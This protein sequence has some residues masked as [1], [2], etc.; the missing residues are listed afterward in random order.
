MEGLPITSEQR[1]ELRK[2]QWHETLM[3]YVTWESLLLCISK[4]SLSHL[5]QKRIATDKRFL[6]LGPDICFLEVYVKN[7]DLEAAE[8]E[9]RKLDKPATWHISMVCSDSTLQQQH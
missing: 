3:A 5:P 9:L 1:S 2:V 7:N 8:E 6:R 4:A